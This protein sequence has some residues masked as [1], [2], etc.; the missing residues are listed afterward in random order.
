MDSKT[1][2]SK[3]K[4]L[5]PQENKLILQD[6]HKSTKRKK[7]KSPLSDSVMEKQNKDM[8]DN[9]Q[10]LNFFIKMVSPMSETRNTR[11]N[12]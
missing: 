7:E 10:K 3:I 11:M 8:L 1:T 4:V 5:L 9:S 6:V 2:W 12:T